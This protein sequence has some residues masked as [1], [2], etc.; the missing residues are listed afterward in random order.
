MQIDG[1]VPADPKIATEQGVTFVYPTDYGEITIRAKALHVRLNP[2][3]GAAFKQYHDWMEMRD[4]LTSAGGDTEGSRRFVGLMYDHSVI[5][6]ETTIQSGGK[7][8]KPT[9]ENFI[10]LMTSPACERVALVF[11]KDAANERHFRPVTGEE[12]AKN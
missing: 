1:Y 6:W 4:G 9:R 8:I 12:D 11:F 2:Q 10:D 7:A 3:F 5:A